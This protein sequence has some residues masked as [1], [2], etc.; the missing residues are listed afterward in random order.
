MLNLSSS[1]E[2]KI[3]LEKSINIAASDYHFEDKKSFYLGEK[4][5]DESNKPSEI[6]EIQD[7]IKLPDFKE[8]QII[9]RNSDILNKFFISL[10]EESILS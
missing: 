5:R 7:I 3:L 8:E 2:I 9:E 4:R 10:K 1:L 6:A